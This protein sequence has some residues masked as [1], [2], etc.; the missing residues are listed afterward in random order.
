MPEGL[1]GL[2]AG[3]RN[4]YSH[5]PA[6]MTGGCE[7]GI[8]MMHECECRVGKGDGCMGVGMGGGAKHKKGEGQMT[9]V[10]LEQKQ[11]IPWQI[12]PARAEY[13]DMLPPLLIQA[14]SRPAAALYH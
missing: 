2:R 8:L 7:G 11:G 5:I 12:P 9:P 14:K 4:D 1:R 13:P 3:R 6:E 10:C